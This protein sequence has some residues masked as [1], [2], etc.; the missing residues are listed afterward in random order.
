LRR[1]GFLPFGFPDAETPKRRPT[2]TC[3]FDGRRRPSAKINGRDLFGMINGHDQIPAF[4]NLIHTSRHF[5]VSVIGISRLAKTRVLALWFPGCRNAE[6]LTSSH[7]YSI[8]GRS[9]Y[10][11]GPWGLRSRFL[12]LLQGKKGRGINACVSSSNLTVITDLGSSEGIMFVHCLQR[13]RGVE[14]LSSTFLPHIQRLLRTLDPPRGSR[15][16]IET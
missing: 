5:G 13:R 1:Q 2:A 4:L 3:P 14:E 15:P 6:A 12:H 16:L 11:H 8:D 10:F 7:V 9:R